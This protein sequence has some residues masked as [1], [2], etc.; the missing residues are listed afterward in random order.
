[1]DDEET[2]IVALLGRLLG[3]EIQAGRKGTRTKTD[4]ARSLHIRFGQRRLI[5]GLAQPKTQESA[6]LDATPVSSFKCNLRTS[7]GTD[8]RRRGLFP[9]EN[10]ALASILSIAPL[11]VGGAKV[12]WEYLNLLR[13]AFG[14][15]IKP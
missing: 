5:V 4:F 7:P 8:M 1:M 14:L 11:L 9:T 13:R 15:S 12:G 6:S 2:N 3:R 10:L